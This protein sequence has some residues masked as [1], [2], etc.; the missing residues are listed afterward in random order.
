MPTEE[1]CFLYQIPKCLI[2]EFFKEQ[3]L[4][5]RSVSKTLDHILRSA[6]SSTSPVYL[7]LLKPVTCHHELK[8]AV[9]AI[10]R[11]SMLH[12]VLIVPIDD[13]TLSPSILSISNENEIKTVQELTLQSVQ[14]KLETDKAA[15]NQMME[16]LARQSHPLPPA[17]VLNYIFQTKKTAILKGDYTTFTISGGSLRLATRIL[18]CPSIPVSLA[19][20]VIAFLEIC[21]DHPCGLRAVLDTDPVPD[22]LRMARS[23]EGKISEVATRMLAVLCR[24]A[25]GLAAVSTA[26]G[27]V[28]TLAGIASYG[29]AAES[30]WQGDSLKLVR[31]YHLVAA[32]DAADA[33]SRLG[34]PAPTALAAASGC[35]QRQLVM[36][37]DVSQMT[38]SI[39]A[40][41]ESL[42]ELQR[43]LQ[44]DAVDFHRMQWEFRELRL[45]RLHCL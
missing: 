16:D 3:L 45:E 9:S 35:W 42:Q 21:T 31:V 15:V 40:L 30:V 12:L 34:L 29:P 22:L 39:H 41:A 37:E 17:D 7:R 43:E 4:M 14:Q 28:A 20:N 27:A 32:L 8:L 23:C 25:E 36:V 10:C 19:K 2:M 24:S 11:M 44:G 6:G 33:L 1:M 5:G 18:R 26:A 13:E 38:G